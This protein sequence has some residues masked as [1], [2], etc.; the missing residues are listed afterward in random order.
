MRS[1]VVLVALIN[2]YSKRLVLTV[3]PDIVVLF[4]FLWLAD[5][6]GAL[7]YVGVNEAG[8]EF[9][10]GKLPGRYGYNYIFPT[11]TSI[12]HFTAKGMNTF[13]LPFLW[14]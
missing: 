13:R 3:F 5:V 6:A 2:I 1:L 8:P 9:N 14:V 11:T 10:S 4:W 7:R 12:N